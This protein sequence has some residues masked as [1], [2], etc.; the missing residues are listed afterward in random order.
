MPRSGPGVYTLPATYEATTG[1][2]AT[3]TQH[4]DPLEDLE[5]DANTPRPIVAGGTG[6][7]SAVEAIDAFSTKG[8]NI[9]SATTTNLAAATGDF[10]HITGTVT[11][12][13]LGTATAG[14]ERDVVF[15]A[16]LVLTHNATTLIL[17][18]GA[19]ITTQAGDTARFR[20]EGSGNWRVISYSRFNS[21]SRTKLTSFTSTGTFTPDAK[22]IDCIAEA[23]GG[24]G[25]GGGGP[26]TAAAQFG[27]GSGG[28]AGAYARVRLTKTQIGA[29]QAV[30]IGAGGTGSAGSAGGAGGATTLGSLLSANGGVGGTIRGPIANTS[31]AISNAS[32]ALVQ[33]ATGDVV[34]WSAPGFPGFLLPTDLANGGNGGSTVFG[35][36]GIGATGSAAGGS[37]KA[38]SGG[39]GGGG[40]TG[41]SSGSTNGGNGGTGLMI[42]TEFFDIA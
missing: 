14:V 38:N 8:S 10:V 32:T 37:A 22:M 9:A 21:Q 31:T 2:T 35:G 39:G 41:A 20:S 23:W 3:A 25:A 6:V 1:L 7:D 28:N 24:G 36:A 34:G 11:I 19:N 17:P 16:A 5:A 30:T 15:D 12:T 29:S 33:S 4:N 13:G 40:A 42:I 26:G 27:V 18:G